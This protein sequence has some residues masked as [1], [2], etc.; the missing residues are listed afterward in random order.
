MTRATVRRLVQLFVLLSLLVHVLVL[1][2]RVNREVLRLSLILPLDV[3]DFSGWWS[4]QIGLEKVQQIVIGVL[5]LGLLA[6]ENSF[7]VL[8][9]VVDYL[10]DKVFVFLS[11][12][13][14][15]LLFNYPPLGWTRRE[16]R[17]VFF[18]FLLTEVE[19]GLD[20]SLVDL[21]LDDSVAVH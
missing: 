9:D 12:D 7:Y 1:R 4:F 2:N 21:I 19:E 18:L 6:L 11:L 8:F 17:Q 15:W 14:D 13:R 3:L 16:A 20:V 5:N 10:K